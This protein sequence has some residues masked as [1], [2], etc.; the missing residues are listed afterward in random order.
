[1]LHRSL[2]S[3]MVLENRIEESTRTELLLWGGAGK[4]LNPSLVV[5]SILLAARQ[6]IRH[7]IFPLAV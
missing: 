5:L 1:M 6:Q 4:H 2:I 7:G 3:P